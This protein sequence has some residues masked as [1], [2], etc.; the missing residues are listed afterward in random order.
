MKVY[1]NRVD[2]YRNIPLSGVRF[3]HQLLLGTEETIE[4]GMKCIKCDEDGG[5]EWASTGTIIDFDDDFRSIIDWDLIG[6]PNSA[7][8]PWLTYKPLKVMVDIEWDGV[9]VEVKF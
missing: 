1:L 8:V 5:G 7:G 3:C 4:R 6:T 9:F 2:D